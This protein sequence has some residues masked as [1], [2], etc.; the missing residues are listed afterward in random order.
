MARSFIKYEKE[1]RFRKFIFQSLKIR[2]VKYEKC[3]ESNLCLQATLYSMYP[4]YSDYFIG[5][6]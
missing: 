4:V 5:G 3:I 2:E 1:G 6:M